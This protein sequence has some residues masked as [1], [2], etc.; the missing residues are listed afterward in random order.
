MTHPATGV[1]DRDLVPMDRPDRFRILDR[2]VFDAII[3]GSGTGGLTAAALLARRGMSVLVLDR[4]Y[5]AGG[6]L[7]V[8]HRPGYVFDVGLHYIGDCG[9]GGSVPRIL[10]AAGIDD[11]TFLELDPDGYDTHYFPD[12]TFRMP[13]GITTFRARLIERFP[14]EIRGIDRYLTMLTQAWALQGLGRRPGAVLRTL[15]DARLALRFVGGT[16]DRFLDSCTRDPRLRAVL[17]AQHA[18]YA[19]PPSR[20]SLIVHAV[21]Q[22]SYLQGAYYPAGGAEALS[23][24]LVTTIERHGG[25]VLLRANVMR[26]LVEHGRAAGVEFENPH[27]GQKTVRAPVVV[28][29]ADLKETYLQLVGPTHLRAGTVRR[30]QEYEMAP[31]LGVV[32]LGVKRDLRAAGVPNS[33]FAIHPRYDH[34]AVY[35]EA[36]AGRFH[37]E[38]F[39]FISPAT[40]KDPTNPRLAPPGITNMQLITVV[41]SQPEAWGTTMADLKS[42]AYERSAAYRRTKEEFA[43]RLLGIAERAFPGLSADVVYREASSPMTHTRMTAS[44]GGT[45]YGIAAIPGQVLFR[46]PGAGTEIKGLYLC[47]ASTLTGHGIIGTMLSGVRAASRIAGS[48]VLR[49]VMADTGT[50]R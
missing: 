42:G 38:P 30:V 28:S 1:A 2:D 18:T 23:R 8:F 7:S 27:L 31:G 20:A 6:N 3:V 15:W 47:G 5:V 36:R 11:V 50:P 22:M 13:R 34:E 16:V 40:L 29:D 32:Y 17:T 19:E 25:K 41:P 48:D 37:P 49:D 46:R 24:R 43:D 9:P 45:S 44:T 21:V 39:C 33:N 26:I 4:H 14:D 35:A 12:F 10:H